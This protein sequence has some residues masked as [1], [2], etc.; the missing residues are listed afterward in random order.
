MFTLIEKLYLLR[1]LK[2]QSRRRFFFFR[3]KD[4]S[5]DRLVEKLEQMIRN[6]QVNREQL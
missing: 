5:H 4:P 2:A 3:K 6:E 1:L